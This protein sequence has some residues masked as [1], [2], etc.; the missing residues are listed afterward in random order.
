MS[1]SC[2]VPGSGVFVAVLLMFSGL[3]GRSEGQVQSAAAASFDSLTMVILGPVGPVLVEM[4]ISVGN[5]AYREWISSSLAKALDVDA[6][7]RLSTKELS[8]LSPNVRGFVGLS[9]DADLPAM[10]ADGLGAAEFRAWFSG[11]I[12]RLLD[13]IAQPR[14]ADDAVRL[15]S[16]LDLNSDLGVSAAELDQ[17]A[18]TLRFRDLDD[19]E[20][21]ALSELMPYRDPLSA[22]S[23]VRP[24]VL[25]LPF[26]HVG[27]ER[28]VTDA[29]QR[30]WLRYSG[31]ERL[32][33][34]TL[35]L[36][37]VGEAEGLTRSDLQ[38]LLQAPKH[39]LTVR[40]RLSD[41]A[42]L[43]DI[44]AIVTPGV[45]SW[46]QVEKSERG[47][48]L[49]RLD[50][51]R[52]R[53]MARGGGAND[54]MVSRGFIG[55][56]F[57]MADADRS[58]E[59]SAAEYGMLSGSL[60]R[61]GAVVEFAVVDVDGSGGVSRKELFRSLDCEQ[62]VIAGRV[63]M[64]VEQSGKTLF[65]ILDSNS[66]R[67]LTRREI[68]GGQARLAQFDANADDFFSELELGTEYSLTVGL[69]R[70]EFRREGA[71]QSMS[72]MMAASADAVLPG[73]EN[74]AGPAWFRRMDR[75]QDG[76]VS[77]REFPGT[78]RQ[79]A[80]LDSDG[81]GLISGAEAAALADQK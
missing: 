75:N 5:R 81:D 8:S 57:S 14:A 69:G 20:T 79:F 3:C 56:E 1:G 36:P 43:S 54:R 6:D 38:A 42:N 27:D 80:Q 16:L 47:R 22:D 15:V 23:A 28:S 30:L 11:R 33:A 37:G 73:A 61:T 24:E 9:S 7:S 17:M 21:F 45:E 77:K 32:P 60:A 12:P 74:L 70:S 18:R 52:M 2:R 71:E 58:Q 31:G 63:E 67:R 49:L 48:V 39:H 76:D 68:A 35:R 64:S 13:L 25:S 44:E 19:D 50:G 46:C 65:S 72:P 29:V 34:T 59:L 51:M 78:A 62:A 40:F 10:G 53:L 26:L 41:K 66:D 4:Q 55:Q